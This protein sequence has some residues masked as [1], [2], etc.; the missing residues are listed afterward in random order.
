MTE[1]NVYRNLDMKLIKGKKVNY[2]DIIEKFE[3]DMLIKMNIELSL[4]NLF[5]N[6]KTTV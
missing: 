5:H 3:K 1:W 2:I 6:L 4:F